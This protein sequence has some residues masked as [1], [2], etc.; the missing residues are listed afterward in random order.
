MKLNLD[1]QE[2]GAILKAW[3]KDKYQTHNISVMYT[4]DRNRVGVELEITMNEDELTRRQDPRVGMLQP[5]LDT[6]ALDK[7]FDGPQ[8]DTYSGPLLSADAIPTV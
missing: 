2:L 6:R 8:P 5:K 4:I 1:E 7:I 3:A